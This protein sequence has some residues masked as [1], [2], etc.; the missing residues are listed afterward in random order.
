MERKMI[1]IERFNDL[2]AFII[3]EET[4]QD[5]DIDERIFE[6]KRVNISPNILD[7][8]IRFS[9]PSIIKIIKR[10]GIIDEQGI[11]K[12]ICNNAAEYISNIAYTKLRGILEKSLVIL[13]DRGAK[14]LTQDDIINT[15]RLMG[16]TP[17]YSND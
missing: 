11:P 3:F 7:T 1:E 4:E 15:L 6:D 12:G 17:I 5:S 10:S 9:T 2:E 14:I 13:D 8:T 16:E